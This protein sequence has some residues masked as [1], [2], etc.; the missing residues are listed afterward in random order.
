MSIH[1]GLQ[2]DV[3]NFSLMI[4]WWLSYIF[5]YHT[6]ILINYKYCF[7]AD[8]LGLEDDSLIM[9][10]PTSDCEIRFGYFSDKFGDYVK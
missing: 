3:D 5:T 10:E 2:L 7:T 1:L 8:V 4:W 6:F 9:L